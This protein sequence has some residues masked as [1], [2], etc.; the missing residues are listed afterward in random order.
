MSLVLMSLLSAL[1][2]MDVSQWEHTV[3]Q[4]L[5]KLLLTES[6]NMNNELK[7][8][9]RQS[10]ISLASTSEAASEFILKE[11]E[12]RLKAVRD[13]T[14]AEVLGQIVQLDFPSVEKYIDLA[15]SVLQ[16]SAI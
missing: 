3:S 1:L 13:V 8:M 9:K 4:D 14:S 7:S 12:T 11:I 6:E 5:I 10:V 15:L 16:E 2:E